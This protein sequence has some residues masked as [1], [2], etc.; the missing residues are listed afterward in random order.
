VGGLGG[1]NVV[2]EDGWIWFGP[3][4]I[5]LNPPVN[6][7]ITKEANTLLGHPKG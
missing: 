3:K 4:A 7:P 6:K 1:Q 2:G 5:T